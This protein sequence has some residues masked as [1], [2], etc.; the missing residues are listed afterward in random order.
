M[1]NIPIG[2]VLK[3]YGYVTDAHIHEALAYQKTEDGHGKR[4]GTLLQELGFVSER[5]VLECLGKKLE[6][7]L[8]SLGEQDVSVAAVALVPKQIAVK[9]RVLPIRIEENSLVLAMCD[10]LDF[11]AQE[12]IRQIVDRPLSIVLM[13]TT[14]VQRGIDYYYSEVGAQQA[15]ERANISAVDIAIPTYVEQADDDDEVPVIQ[16]V[17][18]LLTKGYMSGASD[19]HVEPFEDFTTV[20]M[21]VDGC[22]VEYVTLQKSL[23]GA[24]VAR[25]KIMSNL[26]I[27]EKRIPQDGNFRVRLEERDISVRVSVIPTIYGEKI[28][29]RYLSSDTAIDYADCFGM[30]PGPYQKLVR[31]LQA[32]NGI[33]YLTGPTGSGKTTTLYM[34]LEYLAKRQV[35]ISTIEDPVERSVARV[36]QMSVNTAA[37]LTFEKGLRALLRQDPDIIMLG[38]TRDTETAEISVRAA[39]TGHL[40]LSTLHTND[41]VSSIVRLEDMGVAPYLIANSLVG[42]VAQRLVR[43]VCD[44]CAYGT[45]PTAEERAVIGDDIPMIRKGRGCPNCNQTG[46]RGRVAV[47]EI[48]V[49]DKEMKRMIARRADSEELLA[50]CIREQRMETLRESAM[51][52][53]RR[54]ITTPEEVLKVAYYAE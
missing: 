20:R 12:D 15:A 47:H 16:L 27:A 43:K 1:K 23:H 7:P 42:V 38:E 40:V 28:V 44:A 50:H 10:P 13:E 9:Y 30:A 51:A 53:L 25:I 41:A 18:S 45:V 35:N 26:D 24:V 33:I 37:G 2:E 49:I 29:M 11:Y 36:N 54:G 19:I 22:I 8:Y 3:E 6:L 4:L 32:P 14:E 39:I 5:Q 48:A 31:M 52:L 46:Y 17:N 34:V 21:R